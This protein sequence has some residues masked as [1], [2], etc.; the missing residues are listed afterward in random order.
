MVTTDSR[1][2]ADVSAALADDPRLPYADEIAV[3]AYQGNVTLRGTMGSFAQR[4]AAVSDA[5]RTVGV[6][7]V[8]DELEVRLLDDDRRKDAEIRGHA[9]QRLIWDPELPGDYLDVH[10]ADGWVTLGGD[11]D[12]QFQSDA[13]FND[14]A[15][16]HGV[17]GVTNKIVV[18]EARIS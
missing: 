16:L 11:V 8:Y 18:T 14:V 17:T 10:V 9:L 12:Y 7:S 5:R 2:R 4:R 3:S 13:A 15:G 1:V 6:S